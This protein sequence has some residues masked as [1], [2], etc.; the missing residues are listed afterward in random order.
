MKH[1]MGIDLH[2]NNH[3]VS[4]IDDNDQRIIEKRLPNNLSSTLKLLS[5]YKNSIQAI[6]I[7][8]TLTI[9]GVTHKPEVVNKR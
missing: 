4:I 8:S 5:P 9:K 3:F 7:E 1:Y 2:S 6:A